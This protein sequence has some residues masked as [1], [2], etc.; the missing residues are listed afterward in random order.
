MSM[1]GVRRRL[2][3]GVAATLLLG[4]LGP[5]GLGVPRAASAAIDSPLQVTAVTPWV[6][7]LQWSAPPQ[8][9]RI[10]IRR[11]GRLLEDVT[12]AGGATLSYTDHLLWPSTAYVYELIAFN[13]GNAIV[14]DTTASVTTPA[15]SGTFPPLYDPASFWNQPIPST[16]TVDPNSAAM[17][18][19]SLVS[20]AASA[21]FANSN[22][23]GKPLAYASTVSTTY[24]VGCVYYDC[25]TPVTFAIPRYAAP[26][27]GADHHL[28]VLDPGANREL[29][30]WLASYDAPADSWSAGSRYVTASNGWGAQCAPGQRCLAAVAAGFAAFGGIV[31]PEEIAQGHIDH[32]L[33][34]ASPYTRAGDVACPATH[35]DGW[36]NDP[37][38]IPEGARIQLDPGFDVD[39][40][41][42]PTWEKVIAHALQSYGAYL[43]DSGGSVAFSAEASLDRGYDAWPLAGVPGP[44]PS[45][46]NLP[47]SSFRVLQ[48]EL[49]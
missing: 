35:T 14:S 5:G 42:W 17:V 20:Y 23:W 2:I 18:S 40:Q 29:D 28:V 38:A 30:M 37:A 1:R 9:A 22:Q 15:Q 27:T 21:N 44:D 8:V 12:F 11:D 3:T 48:V 36:A 45:L 46:A 16:A 47:W 39:S 34:F 10:E 13:P 25:A 19:A 33:F 43:G 32:A 7:A 49:C 24:P 41:A 26:S 6:A 31:R 4:T